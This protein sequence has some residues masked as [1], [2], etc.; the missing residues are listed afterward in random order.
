MKL[1]FR[2]QVSS[3][4]HHA[5]L[6]ASHNF[7]FFAIHYAPVLAVPEVGPCRSPFYYTSYAASAL[8]QDESLITE[9]KNSIKPDKKAL[10]KLRG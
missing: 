3:C 5:L 2:T 1:Y 4:I 9:T 8:D 10:E 6:L 7:A